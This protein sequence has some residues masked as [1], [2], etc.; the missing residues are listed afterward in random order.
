MFDTSRLI[1]ESGCR[2]TRFGVR[3]G[4]FLVCDVPR[5]RGAVLWRLKLEA[6]QAFGG[7]A[8]DAK[9]VAGLAGSVGRLLTENRATRLVQSSSLMPPRARTRATSK[10]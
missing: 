1:G 3:I 10:T 9:A 2:L 5:A 6:L 7:V 8:E 4:G